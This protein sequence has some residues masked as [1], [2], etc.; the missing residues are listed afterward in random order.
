M[1]RGDEEGDD[2][3]Q[4]AA[5]LTNEPKVVQTDQQITHIDEDGLPEE[6]GEESRKSQFTNLNGDNSSKGPSTRQSPQDQFAKSVRRIGP[7]FDIGQRDEILIGSDEPIEL[8]SKQKV[9]QKTKNSF[10]PI[11]THFRQ[12]PN[13]LDQRPGKIEDT[14]S[15]TIQE[16]KQTLPMDEPPSRNTKYEVIRTNVFINDLQPDKSNQSIDQILKN[17]YFIPHFGNGLTS[18]IGDETPVLSVNGRGHAGLTPFVRG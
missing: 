17:D 4:F 10:V 8:Y 16:K 12:K 9:I 15:R 1:Q 18:N 5:E 7:G 3:D 14:A 13:N 6:R 2:G 11:L